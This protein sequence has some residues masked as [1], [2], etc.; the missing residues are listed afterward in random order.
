VINGS[1]KGDVLGLGE[2]KV[3]EN[4]NKAVEAVVATNKNDPTVFTKYDVIVNLADPTK[5]GKTLTDLEISIQNV[6]PENDQTNAEVY[7]RVTAYNS[8]KAN[9]KSITIETGKNVNNNTGTITL[10]PAN[11]LSGSTNQWGENLYN[12]LTKIESNGVA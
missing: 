10:K 2:L 7:D 12:V 8:I 9:D 5:T 4:A 1:T 6:N 11:S 3:G